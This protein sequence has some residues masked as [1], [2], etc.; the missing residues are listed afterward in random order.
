MEEA[1]EQARSYGYRLTPLFLIVTNAR[2][3]LVAKRHGFR[4]EEKVFDIPLHELGFDVVKRFKE[5]LVG[6]Q[7]ASRLRDGLAQAGPFGTVEQGPHALSRGASSVA[8]GWV[9]RRTTNASGRSLH[10]TWKRVYRLC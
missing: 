7:T 1:L 8:L 5:Q 10:P 9:T 3:L 6:H 2:R 4:R